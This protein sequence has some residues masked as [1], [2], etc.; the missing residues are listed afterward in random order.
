MR[1]VRAQCKDSP[2]DDWVPG[3]VGGGADA[4]AL[5][6]SKRSAW[7]VKMKTRKV[8][9]CPLAQAGIAPGLRILYCFGGWVG[10]WVGGCPTAPPP[11]R[12]GGGTILGPWVF[13]KS[14]WVGFIIHPPPPAPCPLPP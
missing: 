10:G 13:P 11:P 7:E 5:K 4:Q 6:G 3:Q 12:S 8:L 1:A 9:S 14:G 2:S